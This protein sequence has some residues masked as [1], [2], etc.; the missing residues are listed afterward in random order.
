MAILTSSGRAAQAIATAS[1]PLHLAWGAGDPSWD[2]ATPAEPVEAT[3]LVAEIGRRGG[4]QLAFVVRD[5]L[6]GEI[7]LPNGKWRSVGI[8]G[9]DGNPVQ[10]VPSGSLYA[11]WRFDYVD[12]MSP[13]PATIRELGVFLGTVVS[14]GVL[15]AVPGQ[16]Y[17]TPSELQATGTLLSLQRIARFT[18]TGDT[19]P[20]FSFILTF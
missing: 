17:F 4:P 20:E 9:P 8:P 14:P 16:S 7:A 1:K 18:R 13:T 6:E 11:R 10:G 3:S 19:N 5:D 15:A 2:G 12:G